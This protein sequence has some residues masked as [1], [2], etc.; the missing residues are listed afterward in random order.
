MS[1]Y[2]REINDSGGDIVDRL[3]YCSEG[4]ASHD[5]EWD[6]VE[7]FFVSDYE[8]DYPD[9]CQG[10]G[11][12]VGNS[13]TSEGKTCLMEMVRAPRSLTIAQMESLYQEYSNTID[14]G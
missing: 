5:K 1:I 11:D 9:F 10:C 2:L 14:E 8:C 6:D 13:L 7:G 4:C 12:A 3:T